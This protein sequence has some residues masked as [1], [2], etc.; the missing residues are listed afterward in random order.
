MFLFLKY[1]NGYALQ[2]NVQYRLKDGNT[3]WGH[4]VVSTVP[5]NC[6]YGISWENLGTVDKYIK[7]REKG[8]FEQ[9]H[10]SVYSP[11]QYNGL[12]WL[13]GP[14]WLDVH[15]EEKYKTDDKLTTKSPNMR[16][17]LPRKFKNTKRKT[18]GQNRNFKR[19]YQAR[20]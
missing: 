17:I 19:N 3:R 20:M 1:Q 9:P 11:N 5:T 4:L 15:P 16:N 10:K 13:E 18:K 14:G 12:E 6:N 2:G 8:D 7:N